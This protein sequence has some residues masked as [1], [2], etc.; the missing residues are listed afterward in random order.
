MTFT[1]ATKTKSKLRLA[2]TG[3]SGAGKTLGALLIAKGLGGNIAM[4]DT[5]NGSGN[6]Y[7]DSCDYDI[8]NLSAPY[9]PRKYIQA[10]HEAE[11]AGYNIIIIDSIS[12]EWNGQGGCLD[13]H[14]RESSSGK[15]NSFTAWGKITPLHDAFINAIT[16]SSC[17]IIATIRSKTEHVIKDNMQVI[18]VGLAP[19]QRDNIEYEFGTVFDISQNHLASVTK[20]RT[21][22][23]PD[24]PFSITTNIGVALRNWL[25]LDANNSKG[26]EA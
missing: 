14:A 4:I 19:V 21:G 17:H 10:I 11:N 12:H 3:T 18:K 25:N 2:L 20:D 16:S 23:F 1:K 7:S 8:C 15:G 13:L 26:G 6:I 24:T 5:E 22:L 9:D